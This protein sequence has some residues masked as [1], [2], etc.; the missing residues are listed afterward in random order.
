MKAWSL[1]RYRRPRLDVDAISRD[2]SGQVVTLTAGKQAY[3]LACDSRDGAERIAAELLELRDPNAALWDVVRNCNPDSSWGLLASFLDKR[4]LIGETMAGADVILAAKA[5]AV[6]DQTIEAAAT[7]IEG[8]LPERR[9]RIRANAA[10][11]LELI[12]GRSS[13]DRRADLGLD[14]DAAAKDQ[15]FFHGLLAVE[16]SYLRRCAPV[17]WYAS[18]L[19]LS[20]IAELN[21]DPR[22][23]WSER[24]AA[25]MGCFFNQR[26]LD[27][28]LTVVAHC[29]VQ[30]AAEGAARFPIPAPSNLAPVVGLEF[31]RKAELLTRAVLMD[32]GPNRYGAAIGAVSDVRSPL[33]RGS[34]IE[35]YHLT[36]RY[37]EIITP[38]LHKRLS[39]PLRTL[40]FDYYSEELGHEEFERAT[41]EALGV[42]SATL[43]HAIP[44][45]LHLAFVDTLT[46]I[47][48]QDPITF[49][50]TIMITEG[51]LGDQSNL[52]DI[53]VEAGRKDQEF[54]RVSRRHDQLNKDLH[55]TAIARHA[56]EHISLVNAEHQRRAF[57]LLVFLLELNHR[58]WDGLA[59]F[60]A[61]QS[62]LQM[63]GFLGNMWAPEK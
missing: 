18:R 60:Y 34:Y 59:D 1:D 26:D 10:A 28:H 23:F 3:R 58:L 45:P 55:H 2:D 49:F 57:G 11:F 16:F 47:S 27:A 5:K 51:M 29:I 46:E 52:S 9:S 56:F 44:L 37:V 22:S 20:E 35:Q 36:L 14:I 21:F 17:A 40:M 4:S 63:H 50:A 33:V 53:M 43:D 41:C 12:G 62:T 30:S 8:A 15:N 7:A 24:I 19:F 6:V 38:L 54:R 13:N 25:D 39:S 31:I 48:E 61:P 32:W 42:A